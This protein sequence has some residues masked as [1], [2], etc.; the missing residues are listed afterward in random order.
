M[1]AISV[2]QPWANRIDRGEK[3]IET[4]LWP[5]KYRGPLLIVSSKNPPIPPAGQALCIVH[6]VDCRPMVKA[7]EKAACCPIYEGAWSW[8]L[9]DVQPI[10]PF[11]VRG[12]LQIYDVDCQPVPRQKNLTLF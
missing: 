1:K 2:K 10:A 4:R 3:T 9:A 12:R 7:D 6:L 8:V 5:T 11:P